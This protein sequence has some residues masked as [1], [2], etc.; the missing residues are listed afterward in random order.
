MLV[1]L[2]LLTSIGAHISLEEENTLDQTELGANTHLGRGEK[3]EVKRI[4]HNSL[5]PPS[6]NQNKR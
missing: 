1:C 4:E 5:L 6:K 2:P 3:I